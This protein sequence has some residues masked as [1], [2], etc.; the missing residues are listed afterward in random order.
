MWCMK[1]NLSLLWWGGLVLWNS[2]GKQLQIMLGGENELK[3]PTSF[4]SGKLP[5]SPSTC[6]AW[7]YCPEERHQNCF[8][9]GSE[10]CVVGKPERVLKLFPQLNW[11]KERKRRTKTHVLGHHTSEG[12][13]CELPY[14]L[15][16]IHLCGTI[17]WKDLVIQ[18]HISLLNCPCHLSHL[19]IELHTFPAQFPVCLKWARLVR[20]YREGSVGTGFVGIL[21]EWGFWRQQTSIWWSTGRGTGVGYLWFQAGAERSA[22]S[23][24]F[25]M[26]WRET[27]GSILC[28]FSSVRTQGIAPEDEEQWEECNTWVEQVSIFLDKMLSKCKVAHL[29]CSENSTNSFLKKSFIPCRGSEPR[30]SGL[31]FLDPGSSG[32]YEETAHSP[33]A[34][35]HHAVRLSW[36]LGSAQ[37]VWHDVPDIIKVF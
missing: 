30:T 6:Y 2:W 9:E 33:S 23:Q 25:P 24:V 5:A 8:F 18:S 36:G 21:P 27:L 10:G 14:P 16:T 19:E 29:L 20:R 26:P 15:P 11:E 7:S 3:L 1:E 4:H 32:N 22:G 34:M 13:Y 37:Q 12:I 35:E 17:Q 28:C 31:R